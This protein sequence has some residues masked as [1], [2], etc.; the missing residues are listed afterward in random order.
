MK[1]RP[2]FSLRQIEVFCQVARLGSFSKAANAVYLSQPTVS[3]HMAALERTL[4]ARLFDRVRG[5]VTLTPPGKVFLEHAE[6]LLALQR[7]AVRALEDLKGAV[8]GELEIGGST[9]PGTYILPGVVR[10]F[11]TRHPDVRV[12]I[13]TGDSSEIVDMVE[14]GR[15]ELGIV[16]SKVKRRGIEAREIARDELVAICAPGHPWA[17][18][19]QIEA[20]DIAGEPFVIREQGSGTREAMER[21]FA[22]AGIGPLNIAVEVGST[23]AGKEAVKAGLGVTIVSRRAIVTEL[24]AGAIAAARVK[25]VDMSRA[26]VLVTST[27]R[28]QSGVAKAFLAHLDAESASL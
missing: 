15:I 6:R 18:R 7:A 3:E 11:R 28:T 10:T 17:R 14:S 24:A 25:G 5:A 1:S 19:K 27:E 23:E 12:V 4:G 9:I 16:G 22:Q 2:D 13:R 26:L 8:R 21:E 20:G